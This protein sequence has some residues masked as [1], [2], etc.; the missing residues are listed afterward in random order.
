[1]FQTTKKANKIGALTDKQYVDVRH[2]KAPSSFRIGWCVKTRKKQHRFWNCSDC[3]ELQKTIED[4]VKS[5]PSPFHHPVY[6]SH[7]RSLAWSCSTATILSEDV[8]ISLVWLGGYVKFEGLLLMLLHYV[9]MCTIKKIET[10]TQEVSHSQPTGSWQGKK[11]DRNSETLG[12]TVK[13]QQPFTQ[14]IEFSRAG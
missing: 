7:R 3:S 1:M 4:I 12:T 14:N 8:S 9:T 5:V 13:V 11:T 2:I 6:K 10:L